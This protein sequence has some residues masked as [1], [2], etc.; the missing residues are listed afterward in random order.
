MDFYKAVKMNDPELHA[1]TWINLQINAWAK[2]I[3]KKLYKDMCLCS[4][5]TC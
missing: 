4:T 2:T 5:T 1:L 3:L